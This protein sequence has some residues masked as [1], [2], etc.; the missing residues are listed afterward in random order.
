MNISYVNLALEHQALRS[1]LLT[2]ISAVMESGVFI[3]GAAVE[4]FETQL[5]AFHNHRHAIGVNSGLDALVLTLKALGIGSGDEVIT[6]PNSFIAT[7][8]SISLVGARPVFVDVDDEQTMDPNRL[9]DAITSRTKAIIPVHLTGR[10]A[11]IEAIC[12]TAR[13]ANIPVIEDCAQAVGASLNGKLVGTF[14]VAGCYSFHPLK[15]LGACGD[16]GAVVTSDESLANSIRLLRNHGL[17]DRDISIQWGHNSRLDSV[18]AAILSVK[19]LKLNEWTNRRRE[20]AT[21]YFEQ[22]NGLPLRLPRERP[23][24]YCVWHAFVIQTHLRD[25]LQRFLK[26]RG[27]ETLVHYPI[28][29]HLQPA[30]ESIGYGRN[31]FPNCENQAKIILSLPVRHSLRDEEIDLITNSTKEFF[32][33]TEGRTCQNK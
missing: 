15:N 9:A 31:S 26:S 8:S 7:A 23:G 13:L 30:F 22:F 11:Q 19:L 33:N 20:I 3:L 17:R 1:D 25:D 32:E 16:A 28:P 24:E 18:Q 5:A 12:N 27:I 6:A 2:A 4:N 29:I 10:P 14:G 21:R